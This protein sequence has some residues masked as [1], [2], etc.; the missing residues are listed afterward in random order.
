MSRMSLD[1][2]APD[3]AISL[4]LDPYA[5]RAARYHVGQLHRFSPDR[6]SPDLRDAFVLLTSELVT[7]AAQQC[8]SSDTQIDLRAWISHDVVRVELQTPQGLRRRR[9]TIGADYSL[10]LLDQIAD[11][12]SLDTTEQLGYSWFEIDRHLPATHVHAARGFVR[13]PIRASAHSG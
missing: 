6:P 2:L 12:W 1:L 4:N 7:R 5:P 3:L 10:I 8:P 9:E 11:R 13:G